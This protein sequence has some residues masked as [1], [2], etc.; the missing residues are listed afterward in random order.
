MHFEGCT[1]DL[2]GCVFLDADRREVPLTRGEFA[3]LTAFV[4][5]PGR[6]LARA[7]LR[8]AVDGGGADAFDRSIDTHVCNL[9]K[10]IGLLED[11]TERIKGI[12]GIGYLYAQPSVR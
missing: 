2:T 12:R 6:V 10:K 9:R 8:N 4:R 11:G 7:Q 5:N 1:L 3:L